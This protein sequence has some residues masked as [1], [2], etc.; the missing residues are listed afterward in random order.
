MRLVRAVY[1]LRHGLCEL[2]SG[3]STAPVGYLCGSQ[4]FRYWRMKALS[5][6]SESEPEDESSEE[7]DIV[8]IEGARKHS[9]ITRGV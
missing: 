7:L 9:S 3:C 5:G 6:S 2:R 8:S 1:E 4:S